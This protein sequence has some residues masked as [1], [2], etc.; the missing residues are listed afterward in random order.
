MAVTGGD[1]GD[2]MVRAGESVSS[3]RGGGLI[4]SL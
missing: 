3:T 2:D 4:F 1:A